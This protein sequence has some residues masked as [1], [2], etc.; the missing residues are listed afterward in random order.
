MSSWCVQGYPIGRVKRIKGGR[1]YDQPFLIS[2]R[3]PPI[4]T[5]TTVVRVC[6]GY[7]G[8]LRV[9]TLNHA[10]LEAASIHSWVHT[11]LNSVF[12]PPFRGHGLSGFFKKNYKYRNGNGN[13]RFG[14]ARFKSG[15]FVHPFCLLSKRTRNRFVFVRLYILRSLSNAIAWITKRRRFRGG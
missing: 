4:P 8:I 15:G 1:T 6:G 2:T 5:V 14:K 13:V 11:G 9:V 3:A 12:L 7:D 10:F